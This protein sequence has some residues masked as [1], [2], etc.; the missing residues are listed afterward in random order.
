MFLP[1][2]GFTSGIAYSSRNLM[3]ISLDVNPSFDN[4]TTNEDTSPWLC[5]SQEG[6]SLEVGRAE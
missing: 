1:S 3:P 4:W 2:T 6:A 5:V